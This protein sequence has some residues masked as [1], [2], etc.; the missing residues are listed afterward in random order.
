M[1]R[2]L[3][4]QFQIPAEYVTEQ[5]GLFRYFI[6]NVNGYIWVSFWLSSTLIIFQGLLLGQL[7][8]EYNVIDRPGYSILFFYCLLTSLFG[9][10]LL[11]SYVIIGGGF[12]ITGLWFLYR[13]LKGQ[14]ERL[15]LFLAS[16]FMG[17][18]ALNIPE[19]FWSLVFLLVIVLMF[20]ATEA[21]EVFVIVFGILIPYYL[22][23]SIGYLTSTDLNFK[24]TLQLWNMIISRAVWEDFLVPSLDWIVVANLLLVAVFGVLKVFGNYYR[25]NVDAR[26]SR[27]AMG[28]IA[29]FILLIY[30]LKYA[31]YREY[32]VFLSIPLSV[33]TANLFQMERPLVLSRL[34]FYAFVLGI[35]AYSFR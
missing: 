5:R 7:V 19:L 9:G 24:S 17:V 15:D 4:F 27:L 13:Y 31:Y 11:L 16:L 32:F 12:F 22:I 29:I 35:I 3:L 20:K 28:F 33:Y 10:N 25:Y 14:Y 18:S 23:S 6:E 34:L 1:I 2:L 8:S 21:G 30:V 26:R